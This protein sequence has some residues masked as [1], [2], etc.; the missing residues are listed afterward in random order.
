MREDDCEAVPE[1]DGDAEVLQ[2]PVELGVPDTDAD[3]EP[4]GVMV[5]DGDP[6]E[7]PDELGDVL[8]DALE[9]ELGEIERL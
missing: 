7:E 8:C 2:V 5:V 1:A 3:A 4:L 9:D 6:V